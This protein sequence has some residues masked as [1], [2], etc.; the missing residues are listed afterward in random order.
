MFQALLKVGNTKVTTNK[1][2]NFKQPSIPLFLERI[3]EIKCLIGG[4]SFR[5]GS[6]EPKFAP[7]ILYLLSFRRDSLPLQ[8]SPRWGVHPFPCLRNTTSHLQGQ[9][10]HTRIS[11][12]TQL[13]RCSFKPRLSYS[14]QNGSAKSCK[15]YVGSASPPEPGKLWGMWEPHTWSYL[16]SSTKTWP[17]NGPPYPPSVNDSSTL[18]LLL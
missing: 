10:C 13:P 9:V 14:I 6:P 11:K 5:A 12:P 15:L 18:N 17:E 16:R 2:D 8:T 7:L 4:N 1:R 3:Q